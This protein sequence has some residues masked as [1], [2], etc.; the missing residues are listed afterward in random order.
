MNKLYV[1]FLFFMSLFRN[2]AEIMQQSGSNLNNES[3]SDLL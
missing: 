1:V 3:L 2:Q